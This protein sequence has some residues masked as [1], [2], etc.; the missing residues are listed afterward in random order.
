MIFVKIPFGPFFFM[1]ENEVCTFV[2]WFF[3]FLLE[4]GEFNLVVFPFLIDLLDEILV[5]IV[6][7]LFELIDFLYQTLFCI[8]KF[9]EFTLSKQ[10]TSHFA[11]L[12]NKNVLF[13][14]F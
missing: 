10:L 12:F 9:S 1:F 11:V 2:F 5:F 14:D 13:H 3:V 7:F 4:F 6:S 8:D